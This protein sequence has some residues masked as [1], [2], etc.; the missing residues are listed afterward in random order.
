MVYDTDSSTIVD[1]ST[2][3]LLD[4]STVGKSY[5]HISLLPHPGFDPD[6][7]LV[8]KLPAPK[9]LKIQLGLGCN[10]ECSYCSQGGQRGKEEKTS[11]EDV[12]TFMDSIRRHL[13]PSRLEKV[14]FW[15]GEPLAYWAKLQVLIPAMAEFVHFKTTLKHED[16]LGQFPFLIIT[17]GA[18]LT[19]EMLQFFREYGVRLVISHDG[20][21][22]HLR[23]PDPLDNPEWGA[24][25]SSDDADVIS[26]VS[27]VMTPASYR[28]AEIVSFFR[29]RIEKRVQI[30]IEDPVAAYDGMAGYKFTD[31][32]LEDMHQAVLEYLLAGD[33]FKIPGLWKRLDAFVSTIA[34]GVPLNSLGQGCGMDRRDYLTLDLAGN[35]L[36]CQNTAAN[37]GHKI[38]QVGNLGGVSLNTSYHHS[39]RSDCKNC[40]VVHLC[41]GTCMFLTGDAFAQSCRNSYHYY[42]AILKA[43]VTLIA[44]SRVISIDGPRP[45]FHPETPRR[46]IPIGVKHEIVYGQDIAEWVARKFGKRADFFGPCN[47]LGLKRNGALVAGVVFN[48]DNANHVHCH[49]ITD[50]SKRWANREFLVAMA[51]LPFETLGKR[52]VTAIVEADNEASINFLTEYGFTLEHSMPFA[53]ENGD[54][55][56]LRLFREDCRWLGSDE[57]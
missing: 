36:T 3:R 17:N 39:T 40:P 1:T 23:G 35:V 7:P 10:Y 46:V 5:R 41:A 57:K 53:G 47:A 25:I 43:A 28:P 54:A 44:G 33:G 31:E 13:D 12:G 26:S 50:G 49:M 27:A 38:G 51:R 6:T 22:Q 42:T 56:I 8:G 11:V 18:L 55:V 37:G 2:N 14:E 45:A 9:R 48:R 32:Q 19:G 4:I 16:P 30:N 52:R 15:G 20:P 29:E 34:H 21:G 24:L